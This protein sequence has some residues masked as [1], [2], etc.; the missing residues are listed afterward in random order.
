MEERRNR[1]GFSYYVVS[2]RALGEFAPVVAT[3]TGR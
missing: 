2:D 1:Y 3:L